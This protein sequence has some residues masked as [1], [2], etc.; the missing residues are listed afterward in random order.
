MEVILFRHGIAVNREDWRGEERDRPLAPEG[1]DRTK[2]AA[3]GLEALKVD[4]DVLLSSPLRRARQTAEIVKEALKSR[5][6]LE[7]AD[8]LLPEEP[9]DRLLLRLAKLPSDALVLCVGH[10]PHLSATVSAMISGGPAASVEMK[11]AGACCVRFV[12]APKPGAGTLR[13]LLLPGTLR[14]L[15]KGG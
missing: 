7:L 8:E 13:W 9:P 6:A 2:E 5:V 10:E 15:S 4:P 1:F 14:L 11:K 12:E 3:Q